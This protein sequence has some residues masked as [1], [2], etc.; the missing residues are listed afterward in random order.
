MKRVIHDLPAGFSLPERIEDDAP[1][2]RIEEG[3]IS[4]SLYK[5]VRGQNVRLLRTDAEID[6][7]KSEKTARRQRAYLCEVELPVGMLMQ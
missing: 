3:R 6:A 2:L 7:A 5:K 4:V 1:N